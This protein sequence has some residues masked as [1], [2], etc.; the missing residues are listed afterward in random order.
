MT[1]TYNDKK[2]DLPSDQLEKLF[3]AV[4]WSDDKDDNPEHS[5]NFNIGHRN[6]T[7]VI[8]AWDGE[9]LVGSVRVISDT[10]FRSV[11]DAL[12]VLPE[13]QGKGIGSE[14]VR[15]CVA[16]YPDSAWLVETSAQTAPF[17]E[18]Q[19]FNVKAKTFLGI[20]GK[21]TN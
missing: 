17:Y 5:K 9:R 21:W 15:R 11:I 6:S 7:L 13:Y 10:I 14:L 18:K 12:A 4:G 1:I 20:P 2:K 3:I 8:S 16:Q 19:G